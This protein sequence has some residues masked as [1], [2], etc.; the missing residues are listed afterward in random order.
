MEE[1]RHGKEQESMIV[2]RKREHGA[3]LV[4]KSM[5]GVRRLRPD[6]RR[7]RRPGPQG[8]GDAVQATTGPDS[9][10]AAM[11][12]T[13]RWGRHRPDQHGSLKGSPRRR[14]CLQ[15]L[16]R[17]GARRDLGIEKELLHCGKNENKQMLMTWRW[18]SV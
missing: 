15:G 8:G 2:G 17:G 9:R 12:R 7:R 4:G 13:A 3:S 18:H 5:R 6:S 10:A 11:S 14:P 16:G 1:G